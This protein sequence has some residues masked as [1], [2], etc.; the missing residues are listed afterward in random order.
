MCDVFVDFTPKEK[1]LNGSLGIDEFSCV[2]ARRVQ[3][4]KRRRSRAIKTKN[5]KYTRRHWN[6]ERN[7]N[8]YAFN[9]MS[10]LCNK[11]PLTRLR[12]IRTRNA[13]KTAETCGAVA[14]TKPS[15]VI[16]SITYAFYVR[17]SC[18]VFLI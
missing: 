10:S 15:V 11:H 5:K 7:I 14:Q 6:S 16:I 12:R 18:A 9:R 8:F 13:E 1:C 4:V 2:C 17:F 3:H